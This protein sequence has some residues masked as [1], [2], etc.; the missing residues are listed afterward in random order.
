MA[1]NATLAQ[2]KSDIGYQT[3]VVIGT[4]GRY[5]EAMVTRFINQSIQRF[6]ER[7]STEGIARYLT[8]YSGIT[9]TGAT[10]PHA[11]QVLNLS[12]LDPAIVR[13]Y[14][15]DVEYQNV[16]RSLAHASFVDRSRF[17]GPAIRGLPSVWSQFQTDQVAL[18][19]APDQ[20]YPYTAWYLPVIADLADD[21]D[22]FDGVAGWEEYIVW[23]VVCRMLNR[24][25]YIDAY[26]MAAQHR[27]EVW[28]DVLRGATD[29]SWAG[30]TVRG[31]DTLLV[32]RRRYTYGASSPDLWTPAELS[33]LAWYTA[34]PAWCFSDLAGTVP[35][36][37]GDRVALWRSRALTPGNDLAQPTLSARPFYRA[38]GWNSSSPTV[39]WTGTQFLYNTTG[40][41]ASYPNS[42]VPLSTLWTA[43]VTDT[44]AIKTAA[45][46]TAQPGLGSIYSLYITAAEL[47][48]LGTSATTSTIGSHS[49]A[50]AHRFG[51][52]YQAIAGMKSDVDQA[53]DIDAPGFDMNVGG[54][55]QFVMGLAW[56]GGSPFA[57]KV[58]EA[59]FVS[60][61]VESSWPYYYAYSRTQVGG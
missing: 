23:D 58:Q 6:R 54:L 14:G 36:V 50:G 47:L 44:G 30:P 43:D 22:T 15:V 42:S 49:V 2:L 48:Q 17:G 28:A 57:G 4:S 7:V 41:I 38:T 1:R 46:W 59:V 33:P 5:P 60:S 11:F 29:I 3:D 19:P 20:A 32:D 55:N 34:G 31:R 10:T 13:M 45:E 35:C 40:S 27:D 56:T 61:Y 39:E 21:A 52:F 12:G 26:R 53:A 18:F 37:D 8:Y 24:D 25:Q 51:T 16:W 9:Q